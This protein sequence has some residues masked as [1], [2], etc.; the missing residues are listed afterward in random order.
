MDSVSGP[1]AESG[2]IYWVQLG[3]TW[4]RRRNQVSET[5]CFK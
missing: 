1:E 3:Y 2:S 4:R 5:S